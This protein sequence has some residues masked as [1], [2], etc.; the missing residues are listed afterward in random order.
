[1][2]ADPLAYYQVPVWEKMLAEFDAAMTSGQP[3]LT[4]NES[5]AAAAGAP[6]ASMMRGRVIVLTDAYCAAQ[7]LSLMDLFTKLPNVTHAGVPT[8][9][10]S[11]FVGQT[12]LPLPSGQG[13]LSFGNKAW[14]DRARPSGQG[15]TPTAPYTG[16]PADENAV[17]AFAAGLAGGAPAA[18]AS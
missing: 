8:S 14:L 15:F 13:S 12:L 7:C 10:D 17:R 3:L 5:R 11:I 18:P 16:D 4:R 1:M 6:A 2:R 9:G